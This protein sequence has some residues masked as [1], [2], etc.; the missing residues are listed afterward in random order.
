MR[1]EPASLFGE[2]LPLPTGAEIDEE[3]V[4]LMRRLALIAP[5][6]YAELKEDIHRQVEAIERASRRKR[7]PTR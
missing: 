7:K 2:P 6:A 1:Y 4:M 3:A 5:V